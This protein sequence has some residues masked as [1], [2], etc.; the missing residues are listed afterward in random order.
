MLVISDAPRVTVL[1]ARSEYKENAEISVSC[2]FVANPPPAANQI[3]W[4]KH[5][6]A[7]TWPGR[8]LHFPKAAKHHNGTYTCNVTNQLQASGQAVQA[9]FGS[10]TAE[11]VVQCKCGQNSKPE[12]NV[13]KV[14][15]RLSSTTGTCQMLADNRTRR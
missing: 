5:G 13:H 9:G 11:V 10:A 12:N 4:Y 15:S 3:V 14:N 2:N 1:P 7:D 6:S 8:T